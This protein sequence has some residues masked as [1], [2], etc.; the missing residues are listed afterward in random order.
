MMEIVLQEGWDPDNAQKEW[1][2]DTKDILV[3]D[4]GGHDFPYVYLGVDQPTLD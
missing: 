3:D 2:Q 1:N 4:F